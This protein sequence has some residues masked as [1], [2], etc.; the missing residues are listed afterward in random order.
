MSDGV[1]SILSPINGTG[2]RI[3]SVVE[4]IV[5]IILNTDTELP[6]ETSA[7]INV[8]HGGSTTGNSIQPFQLDLTETTKAFATFYVAIYGDM[9]TTDTLQLSVQTDGS[10]DADPII[11]HYPIIAGAI[12]SYK[13]PDPIYLPAALDDNGLPTDTKYTAHYS[14]TVTDAVTTEGVPNYIVEWHQDW[15]AGTFSFVRAF[16]SSTQTAPLLPD[17]PTDEF[18]NGLIRTTT[19]SFGVADLYLVTTTDP[20]YFAL[21]GLGNGADPTPLSP[22]IVIGA[23]ADPAPQEPDI[24]ITFNGQ[25]VGNLDSAADRMVDISIPTDTIQR[26]DQAQVLVFAN[27]NLID[28]IPVAFTSNQPPYLFSKAAKIIFYSDTGPHKNELNEF[29]Y[30]RAIRLK[31]VAQSYPRSFYAVGDRGDN[32]P[33][34]TVPNRDLL[35]PVISNAGA[36]INANTIQNGLTVKVPLLTTPFWTPEQGDEI[37]VT[38]YLNGWSK[39]QESP[40]KNSFSQGPTK[41]TDV[42]KQYIE[43]TFPKYQLDGYASY[44]DNQGDG[45]FYAEYYI[46]KNDSDDDESDRIYSKS[47]SRGLD[48][49]TTST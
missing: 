25:G 9:L 41:I 23:L 14:A 32:E 39:V 11:K 47:Y 38:I 42:S 5:Q 8:I 21:R 12:V 27:G 48:T 26:H 40:L 3:G 4:V 13:D 6:S 1:L 45:Q 28:N 49:D 36:I 16:S 19:N 44:P 24:G 35:L 29:Y 31:D 10:I 22:I 33:D 37:T 30:V 20:V 7:I 2:L 43:Y 46:V 15:D 34:L 17:Y 18:K